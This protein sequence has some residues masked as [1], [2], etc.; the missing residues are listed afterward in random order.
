[1]DHVSWHV[2]FQVAANQYL[3][4]KTSLQS[5]RIEVEQDKT[6]ACPGMCLSRWL[7]ISCQGLYNP[8][9]LREPTVQYRAFDPKLNSWKK[10]EG[11]Y[12]LQPKHDC[13]Y[14]Y[15]HFDKQLNLVRH[16]L[17]KL[18]KCKAKP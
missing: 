6:S 18:F 10:E 3:T 17:Q 5:L 8:G 9:L 11:K 15:D 12:P 4:S 16:S 1:M 2:P 13:P 14:Y 7:T